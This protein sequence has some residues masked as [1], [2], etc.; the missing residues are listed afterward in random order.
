[1]PGNRKDG[2]QATQAGT[3]T[4]RNRGGF[5]PIMPATDGMIGR[6]GPMNLPATMLFAPCAE[7]NRVPRS[8]RAG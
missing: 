2:A 5:M 1:M 4:A 6:S 8:I 3:T 7:K